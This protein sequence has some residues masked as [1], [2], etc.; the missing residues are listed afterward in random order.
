MGHSR[1]RVFVPRFDGEPDHIDELRKVEHGKEATKREPSQ[2]VAGLFEVRR[3]YASWQV[4][5]GH[6]S[7]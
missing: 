6:S 7:V 1:R 4:Y 5:H 3:L 2:P